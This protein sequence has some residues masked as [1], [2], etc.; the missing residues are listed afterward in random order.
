MSFRIIK[1]GESFEVRNENNTLYGPVCSSQATAEAL[2]EDWE[3]DH[4]APLRFV[5]VASSGNSQKW[6]EMAPPAP[7]PENRRRIPRR[8]ILGF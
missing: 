4:A 2:Q 7:E 1:S 6:V 8:S 3:T 5:P